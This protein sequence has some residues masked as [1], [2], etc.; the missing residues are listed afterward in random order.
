MRHRCVPIRVCS[1][2]AVVLLLI[3]AVV[4]GAGAATTQTFNLHPGWN[5]IYLEVQ[6]EER[7][8]ATVFQNL[9]VESVWTWFDR[10]SSLEFI[11]DPAEGLWA[12]PGWSVY[13]KAP[14]LAP[15]TNLF[16]IF[17]NRAYLIKLG[18]RQNVTW[19]VTGEPS[20][21]KIDWTA[22]SFNLVGFHVNPANPAT[23]AEFLGDIPS[24]AGQPVFRLSAAGIWERVVDP[25]ATTI[26][27]GEAYWVY[28]S[29]Y[30][31]FQSP[32]EVKILGKDIDFGTSAT[33][34]TVTLLNQTLS[35]RTVVVK[36]QPAADWLTYQTYNTTSGFYE[37]PRLDTLTLQIPAD[38]ESNLWLAVR[39]ELLTNGISGGQLEVTD[40]RGTRWII[41]VRVERIAQ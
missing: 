21:T 10:G 41:P 6:P 24:L 18:G 9:P 34:K 8:P 26:S 25:G 14:E 17:A 38:R 29:G 2:A 22:D 31:A 11:R 7:A 12:E 16:A 19:S 5:A 23:F 32:V 13:A 28:C 1:V 15:A 35:T 3:F 37:Y 27:S 20:T 33:L 36:F 4:G 30:S 39:R 40:D